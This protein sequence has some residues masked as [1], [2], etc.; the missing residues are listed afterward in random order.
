[1]GNRQS[2]LENRNSTPADYNPE[3]GLS[4]KG[5]HIP[6]EI[7]GEIF[8]KLPPSERLRARL[9][10]KQWNE[11]IIYVLYNSYNKY[12]KTHHTPETLPFDLC[13]ITLF[14]KR[15]RQN[16]LKNVNGEEGFKYWKIL[17]N[18]GDGII[19]EDLP[20]GSDEL[21]QGIEEFNGNTSCFT[22]SYGLGDK[23]Q[24]ILVSQDKHLSHIINTYKPAI[25][26]SEWVAARF[27]CGARYSMV[28]KIV[29][30]NEFV[31]ERVVHQVEQW[32]GR[33]W[34]KVS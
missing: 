9:V 18:G 24:E 5:Y 10:C 27:D 2:N 23:E 11:I 17:A 20:A 28:V 12:F 16:L 29:C 7:L 33:E 32:L 30:K 34:S 15:L 8:R 4:L 21:P 6:E 31:E 1:M 25:Y 14:S 22:T 19:V 13:Y 26:V 3:N